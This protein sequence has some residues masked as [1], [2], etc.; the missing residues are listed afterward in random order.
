MTLLETA[1]NLARLHHTG[2][3]RRNGAPYI[4]HLE[5]VAKRCEKHSEDAQ[6]VAYLH[7]IFEDT[8]ASLDLL[9]SNFP[10]HIQNAVV[11]LTKKAG[12][13]YEQYISA[14]A[15]N[16]LAK[17][18]KVEDMLDNISDA[19]TNRQIRKYAQALLMLVPA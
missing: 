18:V 16:K 8:D 10:V 6:I 11:L 1:R 14:I 4:Q 2:Q 17:Q 19:P 3:L 9:Y 7:D 12:Q 13:S 5:N 15:A